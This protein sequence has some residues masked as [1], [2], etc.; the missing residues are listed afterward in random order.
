M[1]FGE[2]GIRDNI[3][4]VGIIGGLGA[5][6]TAE[7]YLK[8]VFGCQKA[9]LKSRPQIV[10]SN[11][12]LPLEVERDFIEKN[13]G[14][15]RYIPFL[16]AEAKRLEKS[17]VNFLVVPCNSVHVFI[18]EIRNSVNIPV[19]SIIEETAKYIKKNKFEKVGIVSTS[20]TVKE[21]IYE[22]I[23]KKESI[24][25]VV[26]NELQLAEL[27][28]I[29]HNIVNGIHLNKDREMMMFVIK[30]LKEQGADAISLA[31]TDLQMLLPSENEILV[32]DEFVIFDT[33]KV[34]ANATVSE[35]I[36]K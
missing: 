19:L 12:P 9:N 8:I 6:S 13:E 27:N 22:D 32:Y 29:I 5:E 11:V 1:N 23:F 24:S 35:I 16:T 2:K 25:F 15:E 7:F 17:G 26:P 30:D 31:C 21:H 34:L 10:I 33:M 28:K 36:N 18:E 20:V 14:I 4:S 3:K